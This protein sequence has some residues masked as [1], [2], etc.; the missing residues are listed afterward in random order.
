M[1]AVT[2]E[3]SYQ[4]R[5]GRDFTEMVVSGLGIERWLVMC[6]MGAGQLYEVFGEQL[7]IQ[8][9]RKMRGSR[10]DDSAVKGRDQIKMYAMLF[11]CVI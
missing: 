7:Y 9:H 5:T 8:M 3:S 4:C 6:L 11:S 2:Q 1:T 10:N